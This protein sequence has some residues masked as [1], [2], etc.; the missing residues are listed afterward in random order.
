MRTLFIFA[1]WSFIA[2]CYG[3]EVVA[4]ELPVL[5]ARP[6]LE[7]AY[8]QE[9]NVLD[10]NPDEAFPLPVSSRL[11]PGT[12]EKHAIKN[13]VFSQSFFVIGDDAL[14]RAWLKQHAQ[15]LQ[16]MH[17]IGFVTNVATG[18]ALE[19]LNQLAKTPLQ[20]VDVDELAHLLHVRHYPFVLDEGVVWQ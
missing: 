5:D 15:H 1:F 7:S 10:V 12:I 20:P 18:K 4:H 11:S 16:Q 13:N 19:A 2:T 9:L 6:Y 8:P 14:S 17:A 3:L